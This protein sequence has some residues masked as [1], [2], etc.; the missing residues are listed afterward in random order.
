MEFILLGKLLIMYVVFI[1][2]EKKSCIQVRWGFPCLIDGGKAPIAE[3]LQKK[4][5]QFTT[6]QQIT[7]EI[8]KQILD[9][10]KTIDFF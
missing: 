9:L 1:T 7:R 5:M 4:L 2:Q 10:E 8:K 6:N 3:E